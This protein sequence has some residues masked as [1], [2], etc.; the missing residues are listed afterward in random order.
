MRLADWSHG[1]VANCWTLRQLPEILRTGTLHGHNAVKGTSGGIHLLIRRAASA[2]KQM[3]QCGSTGAV[4][5]K[6]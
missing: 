6:R 2:S 4:D 5:S 3:L 1:V